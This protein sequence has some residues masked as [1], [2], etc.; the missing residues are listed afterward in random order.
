MAEL[1]AANQITIAKV[2]DG[3]KGEMSA[4][5]LA[6]LN[7]A[8]QDA[9]D[10]VSKVDNLEIGGRNVLLRTKDFSSEKWYIK[11]ISTPV[12]DDD[13]FYYCGILHAWEN[14]IHQSALLELNEV[15]TCSFYAKADSVVQLEI[16]DDSTNNEV[17]KYISITSTEWQRYTCTFTKHINNS[18]TSDVAF[19][20]RQANTT[21]YIKKIKIEK[22]NKAT[23]WTPAPED[24]DAGIANASKVATNFLEYD[25]TNGLIVGNKTS[26]SWSGYRSQILPG[27]FNILDESS[28]VLASFGP[29][30]VIGEEAKANLHLTF[31]NFSMV[32]K[33]GA[34]FFEVGDARNADGI[35]TI[36]HT[37]TVTVKS[38]GSA[39]VIVESNISSIVSIY[40]D[41]VQLSSSKY[42]FSGKTV[43]INGLTANLEKTIKITYTT[44]EST[45]YLTFGE[46]DSSGN[47]GNYSVAEGYNVISSG[48]CSCAKGFLTTASGFASHA[49][50]ESTTA[51][52]SASHAEGYATTASGA[53]SHAG[54]ISTVAD[55]RAMTAIGKWNTKNS[56]KAFVVGNGTKD[57]TRSDAFTVDWDGNTVMKG[58]LT[59]GAPLSIAN[60]GTGAK[61]A[62]AAR[63]N[64]GL[65]GAETKTLLW[66]NASPTSAF[67]AQDIGV[68]NIDNFDFVE[69]FYRFNINE[70]NNASTK[71]I[72][73]NTISMQYGFGSSEN[74]ERKITV[75]S[76]TSLHFESAVI[77]LVKED[78]AYIIPLKIYGI[79]GV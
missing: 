53:A 63:A 16:K 58:G 72:S 67:G 59:L 7:K 75:N 65:T 11:G 1:L 55:G 6:Q 4:E 70:N 51:S 21:I 43:T 22:G 30:T 32:D 41:S 69:V 39:T 42:S 28:T 33:D 49:E 29:T 9:S 27:S 26:G 35:A 20:T 57:T 62:A 38:T 76:N 31:N 5:Q 78:N 37:E 17:L 64:L 34:K 8:S 25:S 54:G 66:T 3:E 73:G 50:G 2:L 46:R 60:G 77:Q 56:G 61:T 45:V 79:K 44:T 13:G 52:Y 10:A 23:D 19:L 48:Y 15:Y 12:L 47:I 36:K 40:A 68:S 74:W 18:T 14:Y 24:V 71:V